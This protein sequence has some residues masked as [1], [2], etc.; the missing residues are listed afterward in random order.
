MI[1][2]NKK[3]HKF[4]ILKGIFLLIIILF[5]D[6]LLIY[7]KSSYVINIKSRFIIKIS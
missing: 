6:F 5:R 1:S 2:E 4:I 3:I 7:A